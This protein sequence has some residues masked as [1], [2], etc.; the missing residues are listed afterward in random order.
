MKH[1]KNLC[2]LAIIAVMFTAC[3]NY[4]TPPRQ[5][6]V[7]IDPA[8]VITIAELQ[9]LFRN[10]ETPQALTIRDSVVLPDRVVR[11]SVFISG[12]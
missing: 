8:H 12:Q 3:F 11:D 7:I 1:L 4:D 6:P 2:I 5:E 9:G 10:Q